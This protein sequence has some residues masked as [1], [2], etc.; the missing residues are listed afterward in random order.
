MSYEDED[1]STVLALPGVQTDL[2]I[3]WEFIF[4]RVITVLL[5]MFSIWVILLALKKGQS[6]AGLGTAGAVGLS[7]VMAASASAF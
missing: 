4:M 6:L 1:T 2:V 7:G 5:V 3:H